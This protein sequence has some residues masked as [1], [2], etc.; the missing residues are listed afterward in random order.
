[1]EI[2]LPKSGSA[3]QILYRGL[4][5]SPIVETMIELL[6]DGMVMID[7]GAHIG[8]Y[9]LIGAKL[10]GPIGQVHA[11]E[12]QPTL[13]EMIKQNAARNDLTN[14]KVYNYA[15]ADFNGSVSFFAD[16]GSM[17]GWIA[18]NPEGAAAVPCTTLE[19]LVLQN[20]LAR[21]DLVKIDAAGNELSVLQGG[22]TLLRDGRPAII[23]KL[24]HPAV[25]AERF[26]YDARMTIELLR[27]YEYELFLLDGTAES[28]N[29]PVYALNQIREH[30]DRGTYG[31]HVLALRNGRRAPHLTRIFHQ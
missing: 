18:A 30:F 14:V 21:I 16:P 29:H 20:N 17:A 5:S 9:T 1:M 24:Y 8:E 23:F 6:S 3:A 27:S 13:A 31:L 15:V 22:T 2:C 11:F 4:S 19:Q 26:G 28:A 7:I 25:I 10:V 12:P